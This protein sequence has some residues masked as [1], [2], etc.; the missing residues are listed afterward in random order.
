MAFSV[1]VIFILC[2]P[3]KNSEF[4]INILDRVFKHLRVV[5][6]PNKYLKPVSDEILNVGKVTSFTEMTLQT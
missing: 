4:I 1:L 5:T 6:S 3:N 2:S